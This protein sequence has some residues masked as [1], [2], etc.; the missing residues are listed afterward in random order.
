[1]DNGDQKEKGRLNTDW[2]GFP[3]N[4]AANGHIRK[5]APVHIFDDWVICKYDATL[6]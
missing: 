1:M 3:A 6:N 2:G 4:L 5:G